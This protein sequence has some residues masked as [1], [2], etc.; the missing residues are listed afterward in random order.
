MNAIPFLKA[1]WTHLAM[2]TYAVPPSLL[3]PSLPPGCELDTIGRD[4]FVSLVAFDFSK[5]RVLGIPWPGFRSFAEV[6]LRFYVRHS[7]RRGVCFLREFLGK[8]M[9][10]RVA[11]TF[12]NEP[13]HVTPVTTH[14]EHSGE[15]IVVRREISPS[16]RKHHV[17]VDACAQAT[18]P[19]SNSIDHFIIE[20]EWGFGTSRAGGLLCYRVEHPAWEVHPI[21]SFDLNWDWQMV[22]GPRWAFLQDR[23]PISVLLV[24]GSAVRLFPRAVVVAARNRYRWFGKRDACRRP[25]PDLAGRF[26]S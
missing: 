22:Y 19:T 5:T 13:F 9:I 16:G 12:Y 11:R 23:E 8:P 10:A 6:N 20:Q 3:Q 14:I 2:L 4:A 25:A 18:L 24:A 15:R 26:L 1:R 21:H 17:Q 7:G